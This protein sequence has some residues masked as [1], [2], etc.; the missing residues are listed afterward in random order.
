MASVQ[1]QEEFGFD[2]L[3]GS[4]LQPLQDVVAEL[5]AVYGDAMIQPAQAA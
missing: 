2:I 1:A 4:E 3:T 5:I